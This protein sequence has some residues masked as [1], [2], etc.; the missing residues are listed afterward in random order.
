MIKRVLLLGVGAAAGW[1]G[2]TVL[3]KGRDAAAVRAEETL[4]TTLS[5]EN[6]GRNA[7]KA[8]ASLLAEGTRSFVGQLVQEVPAWQT[9]SITSTH[10]SERLIGHDTAH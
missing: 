6:I 4:K 8:A 2:H 3:S 7:G 5:P 1:A 10:S 9:K